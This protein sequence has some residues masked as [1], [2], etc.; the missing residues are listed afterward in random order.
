[1][2]IG[3]VHIPFFVECNQ[4]ENQFKENHKASKTTK[5][6]T[7]ENKNG[8]ADGHENEAQS[9][10]N[11]N[12]KGRQFVIFTKILDFYFFLFF[13]LLTSLDEIRP[14]FSCSS[15]CVCKP[16]CQFSDKYLVFST[17]LLSVGDSTQI[18]QAK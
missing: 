10:P 1:V 4:S 11:K 18:V 7:K 3:T 17:K 9:P 14:A 2:C 13:W 12:L 6:A 5:E 16:I 15:R 8:V